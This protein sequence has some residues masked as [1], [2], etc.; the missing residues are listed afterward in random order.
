MMRKQQKKS[1]KLRAGPSKKANKIGKPLAKLI[2]KKRDRAKINKIRN[3]KGEVVSN[4]TEMQ[5]ITG[6]YYKK[7]IPQ[8][9]GQSWNCKTSKD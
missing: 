6:D 7:I 4:T 3:G 5:R 1:I 8:Y 9:N 2:K